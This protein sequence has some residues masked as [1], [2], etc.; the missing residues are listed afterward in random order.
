I[1]F[2]NA[3]SCLD[4]QFDSCVS[5]ESSRQYEAQASRYRAQ[6]SPSPQQPTPTHVPQ[7]HRLITL[8]DHICHI[9][10]QDFARN[11]S[12][13][14]ASQ[15][16]PTST[17]QNTAP[18]AAP[19]RSKPSNRFSPDSQGQ[20]VH[21]QRPASRVSPENMPDKPR[22][23]PGKS[24]ERGH[25]S[26]PYEPISPPQAPIVHSK[27]DNMM[28]MSQRSEPAEQRN[29]S[30]S[31]GNMNYLPAF[32]TKLENTSP[33]VMFKK[34]EI[35]RKLNSSGGGDSDMGKWDL[36]DIFCFLI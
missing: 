17:F 29:D 11:Q 18:P 16:T 12:T 13:S 22:G 6:E 3:D 8:A 15:Q 30:R 23:R 35:F 14:Q 21:H 19:V 4:G 31:P 10:T 32:F 33:M 34:Q 27:Q 9:I 25:M 36:T 7:T 24:P 20:P 5:G 2:H 1:I 28:L 26:E